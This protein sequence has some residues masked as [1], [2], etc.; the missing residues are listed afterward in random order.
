VSDVRP[1]PTKVMRSPEF[2]GLVS[3]SEVGAELNAPDIAVIELDESAEFSSAP[4]SEFDTSPVN[5]GDLITF[6]GFGLTSDTDKTRP[7]RKFHVSKVSSPQELK[8]AFDLYGI[9]EAEVNFSLYF[10]TLGILVGKNY[11][12]LGSGDSGGPVFRNQK[13]IPA[14]VGVNAFT[15]CPD[16]KE[17]CE[18][19]SNSF[20]NRINVGGPYHLGE[21]LTSVLK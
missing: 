8:Q 2:T 12:N 7:V 20:F 18:A 21:W 14:L 16:D 10:G 11:A 17:D 13:G 6:V 9:T 5:S 15:F 1:N 4:T 19:T 3:N